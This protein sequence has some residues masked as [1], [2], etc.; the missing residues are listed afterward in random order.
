MSSLQLAISMLFGVLQ[1][2]IGA[3]IQVH[4]WRRRL[5]SRLR[6]FLVG[7]GGI[8]FICSGIDELVVS[9]V[10]MLNRNGRLLNAAQVSL[11]HSDAQTALW[12]AT[13]ALAFGVAT[14]PFV[15]RLMK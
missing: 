5:F 12:V 10:D 6:F 11:L 7:L 4:G 15:A 14:Y 13:L 1:I 8:W 3:A 2:G 9:S